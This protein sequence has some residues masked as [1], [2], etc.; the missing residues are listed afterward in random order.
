[1]FLWMSALRIVRCVL[2]GLC[3]SGI[4]SLFRGVQLRREV[5]RFRFR[6]CHWS[7]ILDSLADLGRHFFHCYSHNCWESTF[8]RKR[9]IR[10]ATDYF[11]NFEQYNCKTKART[12]WQR[13]Q[14]KIPWRNN[15][16]VKTWGRK[17]KRWATSFLFN[18][19]LR[20]FCWHAL[21]CLAISFSRKCTLCR[22]R[23]GVRCLFHANRVDSAM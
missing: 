13:K 16:E 4:G 8:K 11:Q 12:W 5:G 3:G 1:M 19:D 22:F 15:E 14:L 10:Q 17:K 9:N 2:R 7:M 23:F 6:F 21:R 18:D 20:F